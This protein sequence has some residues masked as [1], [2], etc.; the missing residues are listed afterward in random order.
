MLNGRM[1]VSEKSHRVWREEVGVYLKLLS[2]HFYGRT[3]KRT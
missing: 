2:W 3:E 1:I